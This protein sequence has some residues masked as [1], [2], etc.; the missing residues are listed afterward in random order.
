MDA[1]VLGAPGNYHGADKWEVTFSWRDQVSDRHFI[2]H[3]EQKN[4][5]TEHS[6]V[7][8]RINQS[9][10][11]ITRK[12][13]NGWRLSLSIPYMIAER[14]SP[15]RDPNTNA[16][17]DRSITSARGIGD[18]TLVARKWLWDPATHKGNI[19]LGIGGKIPTGEDNV[20][21]TRA[22]LSS[23]GATTLVTRTV[24]QSI[25]PG[26]GGFGIVF[27]LQAFRR[28]AD[29]RFA[30]YGSG[31]YLSNPQTTNGI[32]TFRSAPGEEI[33]SVADVYIARS[34]IAWYPGSGWGL[35]LGGRIEGVPTYDIIGSSD[36][37]RRPGYAVSVEPGVSWTY[38]PH[39]FSLQVPIAVD[40]SRAVS[41]A[42]LANGTHGD[43][44][45]ADYFFIGGYSRRF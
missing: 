33:M 43:A 11:S 2:G 38:G 8:N 19:S 3:E 12:Y 35:T 39:T 44:A 28:F 20:V 45:F 21:D 23:S 32:R 14:S 18:V 42:D 15:I 37:F 27:D 1:P 17:V 4:R 9:D 31:T 34:G 5:I 10:I 40:R 16:V 22:S 41:V 6:Q 25:Q 29:D 26:D 30:V 7:I 36:G 24:D 13:P